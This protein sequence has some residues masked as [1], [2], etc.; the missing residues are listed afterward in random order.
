MMKSF[1]RIFLLIKEYLL[2]EI[3]GFILTILSTLF[4]FS[5]PMVSK[6]LIDSILPSHSLTNLYDGIIIFFLVTI[7]QPILGYFK[8]ILFLYII[9]K[10]S[11]DLR[12][13]LFSKVIYATMRFFDKEKK[14][15]IMSRILSGGQYASNFIST[16][17][18]ILLK[19]IML[20]VMILVGMF[21]T[22]VFITLIILAM[23]VVIIPL[24]AVLGNK[25][26]SLSHEAQIQQDRIY[27]GLNQM[28]DSIGTIKSLSLEKDV[29]RNFDMYCRD[30]YRNSIKTNKLGILINYLSVASVVLALC[31]IYCYGTVLV[32]RGEMTLGSV[33]AMGMYLQMIVQPVSELM[34]CN[35]SVQK[36]KPIFERIFE[37]FDVKP[38]N[39]KGNSGLRIGGNIVFENVVFSYKSGQRVLDGLSFVIPER[40]LTVISGKSGSGKSTI[41]KL[42]M[43]FYEPDSGNIYINNEKIGD[44]NLMELRNNIGYVPQNI[45]LLNKSIMEN[46]KYGNEDVKP[47]DAI[48]M[49]MKLKLDEMI[50]HLPEKY[51]T[52][53][54]ER[55]N[56][57]GGEIQR[58]GICRA[59]L[60]GPSVII[61]D[62]PTSALDNE[63]EEIIRELLEDLSKTKTVILITHRKSSF[64]NP[65]NIIDIDE[66]NSSTMDYGN[67]RS[68]ILARIPH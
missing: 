65:D 5:S 51:D 53:I 42:L 20:I 29:V 58:L 37:Y 56:L 49:C 43:R 18:T 63:N 4:V 33:I 45:E 62:E 61:M 59:L 39:S 14:G 17:F 11:L 3:V 28:L 52:I 64:N 32:M 24:L 12:T 7:S 2:L 66:K 40:K 46:L 34:N 41:V 57:S 38:E 31:L 23:I 27:T 67:E 13:A 15:D 26:K 48:D 21:C 36:I 68:G 10:I 8:D 22:S 60:K 47:Q 9:E 30:S 19:D 6:Y 50:T 35:I 1:K 44:L 55:I 25:F 16:F 54:T